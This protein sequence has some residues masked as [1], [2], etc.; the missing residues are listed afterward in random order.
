MS[1]DTGCLVRDRNRIVYLSVTNG[2]HDESTSRQE[3]CNERA[4]ALEISREKR[5]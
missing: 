3:N 4:I 5:Q 2:A 1:D